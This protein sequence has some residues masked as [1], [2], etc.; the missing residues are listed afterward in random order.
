[1]KIRHFLLLVVVLM[2]SWVVGCASARSGMDYLVFGGHGEVS[3]RMSGVE[4]SAV[5]ELSKN[6]ERVRVEYLSP[7]ALCG[8]ILTSEGETC[9]VRLGEMCFTCETSKIAGFLRPA[10][11]FLQH[12]EAN[13][14]QKNGENTVLTFPASG[15]LT[16]SPKGEPL[17]FEREDIDM[18][19]VWWQNGTSANFGS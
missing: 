11:A 4:F 9:E 7:D 12:G 19:V 5:V 1:M 17:F 16:L 15:T 14:V 6:G 18:R 13:C 2:S 10:T 8:L 3:G